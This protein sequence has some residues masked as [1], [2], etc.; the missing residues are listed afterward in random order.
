VKYLESFGQ[1]VNI[2]IEK[3]IKLEK[4]LQKTPSLLDVE[5]FE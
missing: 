2:S 4:M 5:Y 1:Q 3:K